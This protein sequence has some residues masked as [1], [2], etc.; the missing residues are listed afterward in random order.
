VLLKLV[1]ALGVLLVVI[2]AV[3]VAFYPLSFLMG[4]SLFRRSF[5]IPYIG[6]F[7][8]IFAV[9]LYLGEVAANVLA[10]WG[11]ILCL[12]RPLRGRRLILGWAYTSIAVG[13]WSILYFSLFVV[14]RRGGAPLLFNMFANVVQIAHAALFP[15]VCLIF[16]H[17]REVRRMF[18]GGA[19]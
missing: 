1:R 10:I 2:G 8:A 7:Y 11:G 17:L 9:V 19:R 5:A 16:F 13:L 18:E 12:R 4:G 14:T 3:G 15:I 6:D